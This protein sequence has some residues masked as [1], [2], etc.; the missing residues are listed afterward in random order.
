MTML[1]TPS[2]AA[3]AFLR[4]TG[5]AFRAVTNPQLRKKTKCKSQH[6]CNLGHAIWH[7]MELRLWLCSC[8]QCYAAGDARRA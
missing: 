7:G 2:R 5:R 4:D 3:A 1:L 8:H 6:V